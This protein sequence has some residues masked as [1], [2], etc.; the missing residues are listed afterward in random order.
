MAA[1]NQLDV[2]VAGF[3]AATFNAIDRGLDLRIVS[4]MGQQARNGYP[5]ALMV[6]KELLASGLVKVVVTSAYAS[7]APPEL[8][9]QVKFMP[10][11]WLPLSVISFVQRS[12]Y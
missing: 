2:V 1:N 6:R 5:S 8:P 11:P 12:V 4:S 10:K 3:S 7:D 9:P